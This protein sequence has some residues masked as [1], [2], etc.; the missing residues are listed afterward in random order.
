MIT[1]N[2]HGRLAYS[3]NW[4]PKKYSTC[5]IFPAEN[6]ALALAYFRAFRGV[7]ARR[8][9]DGLLDAFALSH[10]PGAIAHVLTAS[11]SNDDGDWDFSDATGTILRVL[12]EGLWYEGCARVHACVCVCVRA[13]LG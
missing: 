4:L 5:G 10:S 13:E 9:I 11:G 12:V 3:A 2:R 1:A 7:E 8:L 6:A